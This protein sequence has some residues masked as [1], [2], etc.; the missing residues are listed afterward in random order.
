MSLKVTM[1][2][3]HW[4]ARSKNVPPKVIVGDPVFRGSSRREEIIQKRREIKKK[5]EE[6]QE[7]NEKFKSA[8]STHFNKWLEQADGKGWL[9]IIVNGN[10][11]KNLVGSFASNHPVILP[12]STS[13]LGHFPCMECGRGGY[14]PTFFILRSEACH[15]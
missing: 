13:S 6:L 11:K 2:E 3:K 1:R 8:V 15:S 5:E 14:K 9:T 12:V 10:N 7:E 4:D